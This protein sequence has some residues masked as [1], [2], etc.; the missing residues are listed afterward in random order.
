MGQSLQGS[1]LPVKNSKIPVFAVVPA[2]HVGSC[3]T[4]C[5]YYFGR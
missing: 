1:V 3:L 5:Y 4:L 2:C